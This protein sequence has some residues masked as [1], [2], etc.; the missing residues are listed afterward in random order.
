MDAYLYAKTDK[1]YLAP[2]MLSQK[3][4]PTGNSNIVL[5]EI[6]TYGLPGVAASGS[7]VTVTCKDG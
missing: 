3:L 6:A 5:T 4:W 7:N 1:T 2:A